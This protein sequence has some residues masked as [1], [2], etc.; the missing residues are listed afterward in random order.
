M[1][2]N[3]PVSYFPEGS[4]TVFTEIWLHTDLEIL[5]ESCKLRHKNPIGTATNMARN[6]TE[7]ELVVA[8]VV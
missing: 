2:I 8:I 4:T 3:L 6:A 1:P 7:S 5:S